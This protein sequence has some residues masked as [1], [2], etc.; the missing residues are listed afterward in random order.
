MSVPLPTIFDFCGYLSV[1]QTDLTDFVVSQ[2]V[3]RSF[4]DRIDVLVRYIPGALRPLSGQSDVGQLLWPAAPVLARWSVAHRQLFMGKRV[5]ELGAGVG[6]VGLTAGLFGLIAA[7]ETQQ[8][9]TA[10]HVVLS[11]FNAQVLDNLRFNASLNEPKLN[12]ELSMLRQF[13]AASNL[14]SVAALDWSIHPLR[15]DYMESF[16]VILASDVICRPEDGAHLLN[17]VK[18]C[19][20]SDGIAIVL[21]PPRTARFGI[22]DFEDECEKRFTCVRRAIDPCFVHDGSLPAKG[23]ASA[24]TAADAVISGGYEAEMHLYLIRQSK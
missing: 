5:L 10:T 11:D 17:A 23:S 14:F 13:V 15:A 4:A 18:H 20:T 6:L 24:L 8:T 21:L 9:A 19:L 22:A 12:A 2:T 1:N 3:T 16:D 7:A